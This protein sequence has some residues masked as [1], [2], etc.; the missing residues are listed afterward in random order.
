VDERIKRSVYVVMNTFKNYLLITLSIFIMA[1]GVYFFKFPNNFSFG[2]V[3]GFAVVFA[4]IL[5]VSASRFSFWAN[6]VLLILGVIFFGREFAIKTTYATLALS[7][8]LLILE[9]LFPMSTSL[10]D[11]P[12]LEL[13]FAITLPALGSAILFNIGASSGGTDVLAML[14]KKYTNVDIGRAL[15]LTDLIAIVLTCFIF[16]IKTALYSFVGLT[17]KSFLIDGIIENINLCKA[18]NII[19][20]KPE[21]ICHFI[22]HDLNRGATVSKATGAYTNADKYEIITVLKRNQAMQL[23]QFIHENSPDAFIIISNSSE[24]IGKGFFTI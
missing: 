3:T 4:K 18:F 9:K 16:D 7:F 13:L 15:F 11:E 6:L 23:R 5:P 20:E 14:L 1:V 19:C 10:T 2:G 12:M 17:I 22:V 8:F 24:I 21:P